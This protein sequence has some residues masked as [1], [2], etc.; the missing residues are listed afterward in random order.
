MPH[1]VNISKQFSNAE[2]RRPA[3]SAKI[4]TLVPGAN[5]VKPWQ[6][7]LGLLSCL[8][9]V[10]LWGT[11]YPVYGSAMHN[12]DPVTIGVIRNW[13]ITL[14]AV[15]GLI[16]L[17]G[18]HAFKVTVREII[19]ATAVG[20][21]GVVGFG[22]LT[23]V[24]QHVAGTGSNAAKLTAVY[25]MTLMI[26]WE[27]GGL[28]QASTFPKFTE[29][30]LVCAAYTGLA[31]MVVG[32]GISGVFSLQGISAGVLVISGSACWM[33]YTVLFK[34]F[35]NW[36][37]VKFSAITFIMGS[38]AFSLLDVVLM[39]FGVVKIPSAMALVTDYPQYLYLGVIAGAAPLILWN[40]SAR[41]IT[42]VNALM[43][44]SVG[45]A[46]T[47]VIADHLSGFSSDKIS[48]VIGGVMMITAIG[49]Y[50]A[51]Q[52]RRMVEDNHPR[53]NSIGGRMKEICCLFRGMCDKVGIGIVYK[54]LAST[55]RADTHKRRHKKEIE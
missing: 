21:I 12:L 26:L 17:E 34:K 24:G 4:Y 32:G 2:R 45:T 35:E 22:V 6:Y 20:I 40:K 29:L 46:V 44:M 9:A 31:L 52:Y 55:I 33:W 49:S 19:M 23:F 38:I 50:S 47:L 10:A 13:I 36:S 48:L 1:S 30:L 3:C 8:L 18:L 11:V 27:I 51:M 16:V 41:Y 42:P 53:L 28:I 15:A 39:Y 25:A 37:V 7:A 5:K 43:F 54:S 14:V